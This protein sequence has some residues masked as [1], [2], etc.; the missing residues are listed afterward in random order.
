MVVCELMRASCVKPSTGRAGAKQ[1][2][3]DAHITSG[4][5]AGIAKSTTMAA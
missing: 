3:K 5:H 1:G 4:D 2:R